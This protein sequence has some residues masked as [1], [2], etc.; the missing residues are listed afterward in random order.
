[1]R[2]HRETLEALLS[3]ETE[4]FEYSSVQFTEKINTSYKLGCQLTSL[5]VIKVEE[6]CQQMKQLKKTLTNA[7]HRTL[8]L[9]LPE[10]LRRAR[11]FRAAVLELRDAVIDTEFKLEQLEAR[12]RHLLRRGMSQTKLQVHITLSLTPVP[13]NPDPNPIPDPRQPNPNL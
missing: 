12:K 5:L 4:A 11:E 8:R 13:P 7:M 2:T 1:M 3:S 10:E 9:I 6:A